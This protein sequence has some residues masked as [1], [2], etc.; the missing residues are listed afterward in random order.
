[1][2]QNASIPTAQVNLYR[3]YFNNSYAQKIQ[4]CEIRIISVYQLIAIEFLFHENKNFI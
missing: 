4:T 3:V 1:M 2:T